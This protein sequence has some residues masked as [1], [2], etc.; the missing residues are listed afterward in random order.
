MRVFAM[1]FVIAAYYL[2][3]DNLQNRIAIT[4]F[5]AFMH[6]FLCNYPCQVSILAL[7][8]ITIIVN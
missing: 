7:S 1:M 6:T 4:L 3:N 2:N 8:Y 5:F